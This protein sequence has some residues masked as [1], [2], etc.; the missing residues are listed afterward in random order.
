L[1]RPAANNL[2]IDGDNALELDEEDREEEEEETLN[3]DNVDGAA[4]AA[5]KEAWVM[6]GG[7][8]KLAIS[9]RGPNG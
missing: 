7:N 1:S 2:D 8:S 3:T 5:S 4:A 9:L 6:A